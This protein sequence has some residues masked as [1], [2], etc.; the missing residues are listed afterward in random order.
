MS[1]SKQVFSHFHWPWLSNPL[2]VSILLDPGIGSLFCET[3]GKE[4]PIV[5]KSLKMPHHLMQSPPANLASILCPKPADRASHAT[6]HT[7]RTH[8]CYYLYLSF[9]LTVFT[10]PPAS[11]KVVTCALVLALCLVPTPFL[12]PF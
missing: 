5:S 4:N 10:Q 6:V 7:C 2:F 9:P 3:I 11:A 12:P 8:K 1:D